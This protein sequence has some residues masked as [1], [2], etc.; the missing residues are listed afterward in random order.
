M[1][2]LRIAAR[3]AT[4]RVAYTPDTVKDVKR[5]PITLV[6]PFVKSSEDEMA[7][8]EL[9]FGILGDFAPLLA[10]AMK[11]TPEE[12]NKGSTYDVPVGYSYEEYYSPAT[13]A[14]RHQPGDPEDYELTVDITHIAG[15]Q[16]SPEDKKIIKETGLDDALAA[17]V[18]GT[19]FDSYHDRHEPDWDA[20][21]D[22]RAEMRRER[23]Y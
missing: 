22:A 23:D 11:V 1:D 2:L 10:A 14:T 20:M 13:R 19:H 21:A 12:V 4:R 17:Y 15:Y 7:E 9:P 18:R 6:G 5:D 3:V 8:I 16:L